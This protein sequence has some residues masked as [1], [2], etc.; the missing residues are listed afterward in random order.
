MKRTLKTEKQIKSQFY[1]KI[2]DKDGEPYIVFE[3]NIRCIL[4]CMIKKLG[5]VIEVVR[6]PDFQNFMD[7]TGHLYDYC[8]FIPHSQEP[9]EH[10]KENRRSHLEYINS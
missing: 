7:K 1:H 2:K 3:D 4:P 9:P 5:T 10:L 8:L 6:F